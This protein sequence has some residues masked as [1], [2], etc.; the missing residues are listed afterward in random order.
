MNNNAS[1]HINCN[2]ACTL[3]KKAPTPISSP[4]RNYAFW[5]LHSHIIQMLCKLKQVV[6][7]HNFSGIFGWCNARSHMNMGIPPFPY[8]LFKQAKTYS[9]LP[10]ILH[11]TSIPYHLGTYYHQQSSCFQWR[12]G[13][14]DLCCSV[15]IEIRRL[16]RMSGVNVQ[17]L[18]IFKLCMEKRKAV[19][20]CIVCLF[21][22]CVFVCLLANGRIFLYP[23]W[24]PEW[25]Y[26]DLLDGLH[27]KE[28]ILIR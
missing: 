9:S 17:F 4:K 12:V 14:F 2:N 19:V 8:K 28:G 26:A 11:R 3:F 16:T 27:G 13:I 7:I 22:F 21:V 6:M 10:T 18:K 24:N 1:S 20:H 23:T 25:I 5:Q 15:L